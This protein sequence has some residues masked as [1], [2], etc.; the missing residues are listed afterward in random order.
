MTGPSTGFTG[1]AKFV[2]GILGLVL[3]V[4]IPKTGKGF[5]IYGVLVV[6]LVLLGVSFFCNLKRMKGNQALLSPDFYGP[7]KNPALAKQ[8]GPSRGK[9]A[10]TSFSSQ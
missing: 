5:L 4:W 3:F 1:I 6:L 9:F 10:Q 8:H 2:C 7:W